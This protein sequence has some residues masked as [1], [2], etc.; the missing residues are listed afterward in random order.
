MIFVYLLH[1]YVYKKGEGVI[2]VYSFHNLCIVPYSIIYA[3]V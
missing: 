3:E 2:W 1:V